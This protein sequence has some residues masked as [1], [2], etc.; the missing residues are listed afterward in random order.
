MASLI[1]RNQ[2]ADMP[3]E[4][5]RALENAV[6]PAELSEIITHLAFYAGWGNAMSAVEVA[7]DVFAAR[8]VSEEQLPE[9]DP[10][11]LPL[12]EEADAERERRVQ[13]SYGEVSQAWWTTRGN[14]CSATCGSD[15]RSSR[16]TE[17]SLP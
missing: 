1:A 2:A 8:G 3:A 14:C 4:F 10:Q 11:L 5:S 17:A 7:Q 16:G 13:E 9:A 6:T 12:D 15:P